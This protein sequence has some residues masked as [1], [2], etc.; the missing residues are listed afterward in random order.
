[1]KISI[2]ADDRYIIIDGRPV[3]M[4]ALDIDPM[5]HAVQFDTD[6]GW[7][8]IEY[9]EIDR[10]GAGPEPAYKPRNEPVLA[11]HFENMFGLQVQA[12]AQILRDQDYE[13]DQELSAPI[14]MYIAPAPETN[15]KPISSSSPVSDEVLQRL[16]NLERLLS[17]ILP[18]FGDRIA[19]LESCFDRVRD[20]ENRFETV[21]AMAAQKLLEEGEQP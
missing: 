12:A 20:L 8:E 15:T 16:T 17:D 14:P 13:R 21:A 1:M 5:Y 4:E 18:S 7:G 2:I 19:A 10:D 6:K 11:E 9:K 3:R